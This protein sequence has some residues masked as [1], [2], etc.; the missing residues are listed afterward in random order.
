[1]IKT[2]NTANFELDL[3]IDEIQYRVDGIA[4]YYD[5]VD[6]D[7]GYFERVI[8]H[9][10]IES[11]MSFVEDINEFVTAEVTKDIENVVGCTLEVIK[12]NWG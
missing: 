7:V 4:Y 3:E 10:F 2:M 12:S 1:M 8:D 9:I 11:C 6:Y 5:D